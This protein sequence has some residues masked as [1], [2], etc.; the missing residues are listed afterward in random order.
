MSKTVRNS[1]SN[2]YYNVTLSNFDKYAKLLEQG[3]NKNMYN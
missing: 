3:S 2:L 1:N